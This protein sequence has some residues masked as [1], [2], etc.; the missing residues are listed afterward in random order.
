MA[1]RS[2]RCAG[3]GTNRGEDARKDGHDNCAQVFERM[4]GR[5]HEMIQDLITCLQDRLGEAQT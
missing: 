5:E 4:A 3:R 2:P 1:H